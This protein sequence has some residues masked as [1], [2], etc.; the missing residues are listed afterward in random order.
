M[1]FK[2]ILGH[3]REIELLKRGIE[4]NRCASTYLFCGPEGTGKRLVAEAF[5]AALNCKDYQNDACGRCE[6]CVRMAAGADPNLLVLEPE[7][8][9]LK[10]DLVRELKRLLNY[11]IDSGRRVVII[12]GAHLM[13]RAT[14]NILLKTLEEPPL[15]T[16]IVLICPRPDSLLPTILSRCQRI[17][18]SPLE[19]HAL[20]QILINKGYEQEHRIEIACRLSGGS[21]KRAIAIVSSNLIELRKDYSQSLLKAEGLC[22]TELLQ[23]AEALSKEPQLEE[24]L[25]C[26]KT[27]LRDTVV[28][29]ITGDE[30]RVVNF[31]LLGYIKDCNYPT[32]VV[33][34]LYSLVERTKEG[35]TPPNRLNKRLAMEALLLSLK[36]RVWHGFAA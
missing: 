15:N 35:I 25:E 17:N 20:R 10:V 11:G 19:P 32:E 33:T 30:Q 29:R 24:L 13:V 8:G 6:S 16:T 22:H 14:S 4:Q 2:D 23:K 18:F 26:F 3:S 5:A 36:E 9:T 1:R 21:A 12:E 27:M 31:D 7:D 28:L 34:W